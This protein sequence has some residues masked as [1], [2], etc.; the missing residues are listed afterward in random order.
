[1]S[2][3]NFF[4]QLCTSLGSVSLMG[5]LFWN[6]LNNRFKFLENTSSDNKAR[7]KEL[8]LKNERHLSREDHH[9]IRK[10]DKEGLEKQIYELKKEIR[11]MPQ[12]IATLVTALLK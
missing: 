12:K 1:M 11:D 8:E 7:I 10:E 4:L 9:Q 3:A 2:I 5:F 6:L